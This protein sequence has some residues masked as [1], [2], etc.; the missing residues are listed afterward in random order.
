MRT[1]A[2]FPLSIATMKREAGGTRKLFVFC[3]SLLEW[4]RCI[5]ILQFFFCWVSFVWWKLIHSSFTAL[6]AY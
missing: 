5:V 4:L 3:I 2:S 1:V 6:Y